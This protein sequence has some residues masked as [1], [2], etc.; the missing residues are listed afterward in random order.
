MKEQ[1]SKSTTAGGSSS[2]GG[3]AY[4]D[5]AQTFDTTAWMENSWLTEQVM[6]L[7]GLM[8]DALRQGPQAAA[9]DPVMAQQGDQDQTARYQELVKLAEQGENTLPP[10]AA[11]YVY[12]NVPGLITEHYVGYMDQ[13]MAR[14]R[15]L[16]LDARV[17][18][19]DTDAAVATNAKVLRDEI[20][21]IANKEGKQVVLT[22]HS[23]GGVDIGAALQLYPELKDHVRAVVTM[24]SPFRG[25]EIADDVSKNATLGPLAFSILED[26]WHGDQRALT[27][28]SRQTRA[29]FNEA[30]PYDQDIPTVSLASEL[31]SAHS[32]LKLAS[33]YLG[34]QYSERSDGLV[35]TDSAV[36]PGADYVFLTGVDHS[37]TVNL[38]LTGTTPGANQ[39]ALLSLALEKANR[40]DQS[41]R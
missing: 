41:S 40:R 9:P 36:L 39:Q 29:D 18:P 24:Q 37:N 21:E 31:G 4:N 1:R 32:P 35:P 6:A 38:D 30:H 5:G 10:D 25:T 15:Q 28:L 2:A 23:K 3:S 8:P 12:L 19:L 17:M 7:R 16:G 20:M 22:G 11:N 26:S 13:S 33:D 14:M 27:D 34:G